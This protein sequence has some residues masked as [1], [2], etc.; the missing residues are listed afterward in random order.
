MGDL[1]EAE[2]SIFPMPECIRVPVDSPTN[3]GRHRKRAIGNPVVDGTFADAEE[4]CCCFFGDEFVGSAHGY[5]E[6]ENQV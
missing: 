5:T 1:F 4:F 2:L 6:F 3:A